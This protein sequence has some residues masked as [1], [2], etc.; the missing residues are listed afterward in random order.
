ATPAADAVPRREP[1][2]VASPTSLAAGTMLGTWIDTFHAGTAREYLDAISEDAPIY[3]EQ[4]IAHPGWLLR[5]ANQVLAA[6]VAL[7][8]WIHVGSDV[9]L[10]DTVR[11]G[12]LVRTDATVTREW[13]RRGH[14]FVTLDVIVTAETRVAMRA[15]HTAIYEPRKRA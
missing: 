10:Y 3:G 11:D 1:I 7:G 2:P 8:P 13:E 15:A 14:R 5:R 12:E 4:G 6:N 9:H